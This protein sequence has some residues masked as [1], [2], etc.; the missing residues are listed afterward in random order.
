MK[1]YW[2]SK[3]NR[4]R[5]ALVIVGG[6]GLYL[7]Q[8]L[9]KD[10]RPPHV[11]QVVLPLPLQPLLIAH[12]TWIQFHLILFDLRRSDPIHNHFFL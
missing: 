11:L 2:K 12:Y 6:I 7:L 1:G 9:L 3:R 4:E 8:L 10:R 5:E